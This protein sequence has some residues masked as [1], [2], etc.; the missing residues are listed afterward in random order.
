MSLAVLCIRDQQLD[1]Q[2]NIYLCYLSR[3]EEQDPCCTWLQPRIWRWSLGPCF[4]L[5][6]K[7]CEKI[8]HM[9]PDLSKEF[10]GACSLVSAWGHHLLARPLWLST[11]SVCN[12]ESLT[13]FLQWVNSS[14]SKALRTRDIPALLVQSSG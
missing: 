7:G 6:A 3:C 14:L 12:S 5:D 10:T 4:F 13:P 1:D 9:T 2:S 11:L 8:E